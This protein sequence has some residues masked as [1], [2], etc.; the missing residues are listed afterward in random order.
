MFKDNIILLFLIFT[1]PILAQNL[2][3]NGS[4]EECSH[5]STSM[6]DSG[7]E[8]ERV[9]KNWETANL[10]STDLIT[11]RFETAKFDPIPPRRGRNMV[12]IVTHGDF[13]S[14]YAKV[15][16]IEPMV[17]G[18]AYYVEFWVAYCKDYHKDETPRVLNPMFGVL[19]DEDF[20]IK[21]NKV[22]N[23]T[24]QVA[25][26]D[27]TPL[28]P[29]QWIKVSGT[30][31]ATD[32]LKYLYLGQFYDPAMNNDIL[33]G[34]YFIDDVRVEK[35]S[36]RSKVYTP[37]SSAPNGLDNI[38]FETD[39]YDLVGQSFSTL[40]N[41]ANYLNRNPSL[42]IQIIG[43]TDNDGEDY[44]NQILSDNRANAVKQYLVNKGIAA[45]RLTHIGKGS[46]EPIASNDTPEGKQQNRRVEFLASNALVKNKSLDKVNVAE[47]DLSYNFVKKIPRNDQRRLNNVGKYKTWDCN[48]GKSPKAPNRKAKEQLATFSPKDAKNYILKRSENEQAVFFNDSQEHIQTRAFFTSL[49]SDFYAQGF[50]YLG[51]EDLSY[52]DKE[53]NL[54]GYPSINSGKEIDEPMFGEMIRTA[55]QLGFEVFPYE[56]QKTELEKAMKIVRKEKTLSRDAHNI[57]LTARNWSQAL[58]ISRITKNNPSAKLLVYSKDKKIREQN[59]EGVRYMAA[60]FKKF[61]NINPLTI[62]QT[63]MTERCYDAEYPLY[64]TANVK[65]PTVFVRNDKVLV[66]TEKDSYDEDVK[67]PFDIQVYHPRNTMENYRLKCLNWANH[68]KPYKVNLDKYKMSY[69]CLLLA[70]H[71]NEDMEIA[72]PVDVFEADSSVREPTLLI[73]PGSYTLVLRDAKKRKQLEIIVE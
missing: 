52:F 44:H 67:I 33:L 7:L 61:T 50:R 23:K 25:S 27:P 47:A 17:I 48:T 35:F 16:M 19:F 58:N 30:Y 36:D 31:T 20:F 8:F 54:R 34:Y 63:D 38:Y 15:K 49:L 69:P 55:L 13:W 41:V 21:D 43:H 2:V 4:F 60:W 26:T 28:P 73:A 9:M 45:S 72:V 24:P 10:A 57:K 12:G 39:K 29:D 6:L 40:D 53:I 11:P 65:K 5:Q 32:S 71:A 1:S 51:V 42:T 62:D 56:S 46:R 22:I 68:K 18:T 59:M 14:E 64:Y 66:K 70:Y 3:P 37:E